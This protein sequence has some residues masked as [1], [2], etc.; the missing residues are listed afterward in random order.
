MVEVMLLGVVFVVGMG[1][2]VVGIMV[3]GMRMLD[4]SRTSTK[5]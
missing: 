3:I 5:D 4:K 1:S 2:V